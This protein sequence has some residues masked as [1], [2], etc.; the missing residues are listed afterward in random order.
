MKVLVT[1]AT[2]FIGSHIVEALHESGHTTV[3]LVRSLSSIGHLQGLHT[4]LA[5]WTALEALAAEDPP[6]DTVIHAAAATRAL[7]YQQYYDANVAT[8]ERLVKAFSQPRTSN[9][10][11][12]FLLIS[13]QAVAGPSN[14][15][16]TPLD[17]SAPPAP[18]S[19][20][21][22]SK[23]EAEQTVLR[24]SHSIPVTI[25]R[26]STVFGPRDVDVLGVF[27]AVR[28]RVVPYIAGPDRYVSIIYV[29]DLVE[30]ILTAL[31]SPTAI[32]KIY[33]LTN[34]QPVIWRHFA[35]RVSQVA[36]YKAIAIPVPVSVMALVASAGD[37]I[38]NM[39]RKPLLFR[40]DKFLEI[41]QEAWVCSP[42]KAFA[43]L[44]WQATTPLSTAIALTYSWYIEH[45]WI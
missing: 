37:I 45:G 30:G 25:V 12:R 1:G 39:T 34:P 24:A 33:F 22:K 29:R 5:P 27:R 11:K 18:I 23:L 9:Y 26:P 13:S 42:S 17:E 6:F 16:S 31:S 15:G 41:T 38:S 21:G 28:W 43:D 3:S 2:G 20:Y 36:G 40:T 14:A 35:L 10:L 19:A 32:G 7:T 4:R 8:T 44:G